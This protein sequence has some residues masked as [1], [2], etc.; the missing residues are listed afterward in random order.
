MKVEYQDA[1]SAE[2][3]S[4][5]I[6]ENAGR[7]LVRATD[8]N[9]GDVAY[10]I[11]TI[12]KAHPTLEVTPAKDL[13]YNSM[14]QNGYTNLTGVEGKAA[15]DYYLTYAGD[16]A[17]GFDTPT[18][19]NVAEQAPVDAGSYVVT[20]HVNET[21]N[22][23]AHEVSAP[24][25][26]AQKPLTIT[27]HSKQSTQYDAFPAMTAK[28]E[29]LAYSTSD[30]TNDTSLRDVQIAPEFL[31]N[32]DKGGFTNHALDQVGGAKIKP[33]DALAKNYVITYVDGEY[34]RQRT[35]FKPDLAIYGLPV[36]GNGEN[37]AYYGDEVQLYHYGYYTD[38]ENG[39][40]VMR[41][42]V[43]KVSFEGEVTVGEKTGIL[44][45]NGVGT[46]EVTLKRGEGE[47]AI[48]TTVTVTAIK[49]ELGVHLPDQ[50][51]VYNGSPQS[52]MTNITVYD[53]LY[54]KLTGIDPTMQNVSRT[55]IG[56]QLPSGQVPAAE[57]YYQSLIYR[58]KYTIND[59]E[60]TV[61]PKEDTHIYGEYRK[62]KGFDVSDPAAI[63]DVQTA[64]QTDEY[65]RLDVHDGYE[66]LVAGT[67]NMNYN[68]KYV[69]DQTAKDSAVTTY[70]GVKFTSETTEYLNDA[71]VYGET[72]NALDWTLEK[73][74]KSSR[75]GK[76][77]A[78]N[79]A[80]F[81]LES[82][83]VEQDYDNCV[84][85]ADCGKFDYKAAN[86]TT[87]APDTYN[88]GV[89]GAKRTAANE[90]AHSNYTLKFKTVTNS[91]ALNYQL[92]DAQE[93]NKN[94][95]TNALRAGS[96]GYDGGNA[97]L[98][99]GENFIEGSANIAQRPVTVKKASTIGTVS[100]YWRLPQSK[101]YTALLNI[102]EAEENSTNRGL[103]KGHTIK[104]LDLKI[105]VQDKLIDPNNDD[106]R[107]DLIAGPAQVRIEVG[108]TNYVLDGNGKIDDV[109]LKA[110]QI[111]ATY[112]TKTATNFVVLIKI[113]NQDKSTTP[114]ESAAGLTYEILR[115]VNGSFDNKVYA[116]GS[117]T[118]T[119]RKATDKFGDECGVFTASYGP[120]SNI[121]G[122]YFIQ[123]YEYGVALQTKNS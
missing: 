10:G 122:T 94:T 18:D 96:L 87:T 59:K 35:N 77:Y 83:F 37:V 109:E 121:G 102:L 123:M 75:G 68:V 17:I 7:Y 119:G 43:K 16:V 52:Y 28:Y 64:S 42:S 46:F 105:Y 61:A 91:G 85:N 38:H 93:G 40:S 39:S 50:D 120:L 70:G 78:D 6:S 3:W 60:A 33:A 73:T 95:T 51:K 101:L 9:T 113:R 81:D 34:T 23:T 44:N 2:K 80:D 110:I 84:G 49:K 65:N 67:E 118:Y 88:V 45:V 5:T 47:Q 106:A 26:I 103:A 8:T 19:G 117:L 116:T 56:T 114:L 36:N 92:T 12:T 32:Y 27:T 31:F 55:D 90:N 97:T 15:N 21:Q 86:R 58:G 41:W 98:E 74:I 24:F 13:I 4:T 71:T 63:S 108:D 14:Q 72:P 112:T 69:T 99:D 115:K 79:L 48:S 20:L 76:P 66:I 30:N 107:S 22:H 89:L 82:I 100:L 11:Y 1:T 62:T 54:R 111:E 57:T 25:V 104:D 29:G 53:E